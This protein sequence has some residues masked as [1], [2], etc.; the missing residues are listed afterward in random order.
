MGVFVGTARGTRQAMRS[1]GLRA[2]T[3]GR[4]GV[5]S[6]TGSAASQDSSR[7][8]ASG[9]TAWL[10]GLPWVPLPFLGLGVFRAWLHLQAPSLTRVPAVLGIATAP[11]TQSDLLI[12]AVFLLLVLFARRLSPLRARRWPWVACG[13]LLVAASLLVYLPAALPVVPMGVAMAAR[14]LVLGPGVALMFL[15]WFELYGEL[16]PARVCLAYAASFVVSSALSWLCRGFQLEWLPLATALLPLAS[17]RCLQ[18]CYRHE[19]IACA[20][21]ATGTGRG[22]GDDPS[23]EDSADVAEEPGPLAA[24]P[25]GDARSVAGWAQFAFPWKPVLIV[26]AFSFAYGLLQS[27]TISGAP[28]PGLSLGAVASSLVFTAVLMLAHERAGT[29]LIYPVLAGLTALCLTLACVAGLPGWVNGVLVDWG[30]MGG[31]TFIM[32]IMAALCQRRGVNAIWLFGIER[33]V[34]TSA[35]FFGGLAEG[36]L[37]GRGWPVTP[38]LV[39]VVIV[40]TFVALREGRFGAAWGVRLS[41]SQVDPERAREVDALDSLTQRC[42]ELARAHGLSQREEEVLLLLARRKTARDIERELCV[43]NGTAKAHIRHVY[44]KLDIHTRDELFAMVDAPR[45]E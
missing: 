11:T 19:G 23:C 4:G 42:G 28:H 1:E 3:G 9:L 7:R 43:A 8:G 18:N 37:T 40:A 29:G 10:A 15:L 2:R 25:E 14:M 16:G 12:V 30:Y 5:R 33:A 44:Q 32:T 41:A 35:V 21:G 39:G 38:L 34:N 13:A 45:G 17:L 22:G 24:S 6:R 20:W 36:L 27:G 26:A 31:Q